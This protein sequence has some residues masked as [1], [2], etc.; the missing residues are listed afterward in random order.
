MAT[1]TLVIGD[2]VFLGFKMNRDAIEE[3][4]DSFGGG[5]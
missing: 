2:R 3:I 1:P 4:V 5:V